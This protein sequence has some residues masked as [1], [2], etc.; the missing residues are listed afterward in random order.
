MP[1]N[2]GARPCVE[3]RQLGVARERLRE[4][5]REQRQQ[6]L[7]RR[8]GGT[9]ECGAAVGGGVGFVGALEG[10]LEGGAAAAGF[11]V[12]ADPADEVAAAADGGAC[13]ATV[14]ADYAVGL[15]SGREVRAVKGEGVGQ[16]G[17]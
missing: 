3:R 5:Q 9:G 13:Y 2:S 12:V 15:L 11:G 14:G 4:V 17:L 16:H 8:L 10:A 1:S 7:R 6:A